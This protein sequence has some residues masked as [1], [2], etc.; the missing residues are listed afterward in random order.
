MNL[1]CIYSIILD[2]LST[3]RVDILVRCIISL[4]QSRIKEIMSLG[5]YNI[6][7]GIF[8]KTYTLQIILY[9]L[10]L[11]VNSCYFS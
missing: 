4:L 2:K 8:V 7:P 10:I 6:L 5:K 3:S 11:Y 9:L 1:W